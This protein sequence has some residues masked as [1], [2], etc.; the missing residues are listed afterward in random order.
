MTN[1]SKIDIPIGEVNITT[2][3]D[4]ILVLLIMFIITIPAASHAMKIDSPVIGDPDLY[5]PDPIINKITLLPNR[6][7]LWNST[8]VSLDQMSEYS[9]QAREAEPPAHAIDPIINKIAILPNSQILWN[10]EP[11]SLDQ[12][13]EYL[14]QIK[15]LSPQPELQFQPAP[16]A[17]Y[18]IVDS[19][20]KRI[21][22][23][24]INKFGFVGNEQS[25][26]S[27]NPI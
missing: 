11:V 3:I 5:R 13:S 12:M 2:L 16:R 21:K 10:G 24:N 1:V 14:E 20:L 7:R 6:N 8:L 22:Q 15:L 19:V 25:D 26:E 18:E 23:A 9:Q 17:P 27:A 4:V